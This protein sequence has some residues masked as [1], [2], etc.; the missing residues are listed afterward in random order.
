MIGKLVTDEALRRRFAAAPRA[1]LLALIDRGMQLSPAEITA[2]VAIDARL[3][4][5]A[6]E[7]IEQTALKAETNDD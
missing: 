7:Q 3:W 6:A 5:L 2:L 1:T 4:D